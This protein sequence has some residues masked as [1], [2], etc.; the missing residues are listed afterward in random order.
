MES[1]PA[2]WPQRFELTTCPATAIAEK[3]PPTAIGVAVIYAEAPAGEKVY[4]VIE[5]R[6]RELLSACLRRLETAK[7]PP[8]EELTVAFRLT[9]PADP[10]PAAIHAACRAQVSLAGELHRELRPAMR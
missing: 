4:L 3:I 10:S 5:S 8:L 2:P 7:L 9:P 1:K 6:T